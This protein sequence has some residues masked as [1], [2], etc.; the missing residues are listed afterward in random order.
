MCLWSVGKQKYSLLRFMKRELS[1]NLQ[2]CLNNDNHQKKIPVIWNFQLLYNSSRS[3]NL[4]R[5]YFCFPTL[6]KRKNLISAWR[7]VNNFV[8]F[9]WPFAKRQSYRILSQGHHMINIINIIKLFQL[10]GRRKL[11]YFLNHVINCTH[12]E[13]WKAFAHLQKIKIKNDNLTLIN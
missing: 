12:S 3:M 4:S 1:R 10:S 8:R 11:L 6:H 2:N 5:E 7:G 9:Y 13:L